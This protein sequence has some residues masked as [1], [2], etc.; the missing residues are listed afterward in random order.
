MKIIITLATE[1]TTFATMLCCFDENAYPSYG[2]LE[3]PQR[4]YQQTP[5][6]VMGSIAGMGTS[7]T[8]PNL[9]EGTVAVQLL[10][11]EVSNH[12]GKV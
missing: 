7:T 9:M 8:N 10:S 4:Q 2:K 1:R 6:D 12:E 3:N 5:T 11:V